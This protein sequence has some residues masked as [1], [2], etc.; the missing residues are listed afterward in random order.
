LHGFIFHKNLETVE[1]VSREE[2]SF[3]SVGPLFLKESRRAV[4]GVSAGEVGNEDT[5]LGVLN[6]CT[7]ESWADNLKLLEFFRF[8]SL[9]KD[10]SIV[11]GKRHMVQP[12]WANKR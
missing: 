2:G 11:I 9:S 12:G 5:R 4:S 6:V 1:G 10:L 7:A 3:K 8:G